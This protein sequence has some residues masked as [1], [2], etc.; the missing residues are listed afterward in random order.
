MEFICYP[1]CSTCQK[2][3]KWME[4]KSVN[5]EERHIVE[6]NP[7]VEELTEWCRKSGLPLKKFFNTSGVLYKEMKLKDKLAD[8]DEKEQLELLASNGMLVKRPILVDGDTVLVGFRESEWEER[9]LSSGASLADLVEKYYFEGNY[10]CAETI[11]RAGNEY[12]NLG[13]HDRDMIMVAGYGAGI[14]TGNTCGAILSGAAVMSM[15]YVETTAHESADIGPVVKKMM[16]MFKE[17]F[18]SV[19]CRDIKPQLFNREERCLHTILAACEII[20]EVIHWYEE[21]K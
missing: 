18:G 6:N 3:R 5:F 12:Y 11:I 16:R 7:T 19:L 1:R 10:N 8:M 14:Q 17:K 4:S 13:L 2:A 9:I 21:E 20:E 15:K